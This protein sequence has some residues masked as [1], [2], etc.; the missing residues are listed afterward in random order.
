MAR[1]GTLHEGGQDTEKVGSFN[2]D[3]RLKAALSHLLHPSSQL[4]PFA[5]DCTLDA[6]PQAQMIGKCLKLASQAARKE[7]REGEVRIKTL[8]VE[9][10]SGAEEGAYKRLVFFVTLDQRAEVGSLLV[11]D[12]AD[13]AEGDP[14]RL[15][16]QR[17]GQSD[18]RGEVWLGL[19]RLVAADR[20]LTFP[21]A[22]A[23]RF[24]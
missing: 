4:F 21:D 19:A 13:Y 12:R 1:H 5:R 6:F 17:G 20:L 3:F 15:P 10:G 9:H 18:Q 2:S 23:Q 11:W 24:L 22:I 7:Q 8:L 14:L 16:P